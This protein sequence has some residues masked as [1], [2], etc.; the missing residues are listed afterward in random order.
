LIRHNTVNPGKSILNFPIPSKLSPQTAG[1]ENC[2][3]WSNFNEML[4]HLVHTPILNVIFQGHHDGVSSSDEKGG[5]SKALAQPTLLHFQKNMTGVMAPSFHLHC[6]LHYLMCFQN[7][8]F[9][10]VAS[11]SSLAYPFLTCADH[12][13][14]AVHHHYLSSLH[15]ILNHFWHGV[16]SKISAKTIDHKNRHT[17][18]AKTWPLIEEF[19]TTG[20]RRLLYWYSAL[21]FLIWIGNKA[22]SYYYQILFTTTLSMVTKWQ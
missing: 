16:S 12:G 14:S 11:P 9:L 1:L 10:F 19:D 5:T 21:V 20:K 17:I 15:L 8:F 3:P 6:H 7:V 18:S 2:L 13:L 4:N 22:W